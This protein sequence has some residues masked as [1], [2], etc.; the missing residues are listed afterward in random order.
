MVDALGGEKSLRAHQHRTLAGTTELIGLPM[1]GDFVQKASAPDKS[2][3]V[4]NLGDL[5][6]KQGVDGATAWSETSMQGL[7]ILRGPMADALR[8]QAKFYGPLDLI[9]SNKEVTPIGTAKFDDRECVELKVVGSG[10]GL[11]NLC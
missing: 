1:K 11:S 5:R 9:A 6:I 4:M 3:I 10:G 7:Q 2:L 8:Q